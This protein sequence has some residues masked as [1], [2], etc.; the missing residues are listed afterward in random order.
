MVKSPRA[1][2][3]RTGVGPGRA[4]ILRV[5]GFRGRGS[6]ASWWVS[7]GGRLGACPA[8]PGVIRHRLGRAGGDPTKPVRRRCT[9]IAAHRA[10]TVRPRAHGRDRHALYHANPPT[11]CGSKIHV[12][13]A[14][15]FL[16]P[17]VPGLLLAIAGLLLAVPDL[18][19]RRADGPPTFMIGEN[20]GT[21]QGFYV[22]DMVFCKPLAKK[23]RRKSCP[24]RSLMVM[25]TFEKT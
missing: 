13:D 5:G 24:R 25:R 4:G 9:T 7:G 21:C 12:L 17:P 8:E 19:R 18:A 6:L 15:P 2:Y 16:L 23:L 20:A 10:P 14:A 1:A 3:A 22:S 11:C